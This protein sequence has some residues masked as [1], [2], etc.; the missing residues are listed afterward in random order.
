MV[1]GRST[2]KNDKVT[3]THDAIERDL[4]KLKQTRPAENSDDSQWNTEISDNKDFNCKH[5]KTMSCSVDFF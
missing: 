3:S 4:E 2:E 5:D 1:R